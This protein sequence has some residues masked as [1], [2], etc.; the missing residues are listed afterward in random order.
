[1]EQ[2][3]VEN[4][5]TR[6]IENII[7]IN[8]YTS[9]TA[10]IPSDL[11]LM[12]TKLYNSLN[13]RTNKTQYVSFT[14]TTRLQYLNQEILPDYFQKNKDA[15]W[16]LF[17]IQYLNNLPVIGSNTTVETF[18]KMSTLL[19]EIKFE[20]HHLEIVESKSIKITLSFPDKKILMVS[21]FLNNDEAGLDNDEIV[22]SFFINRKLIASDVSKLPSFVKNFKEYL[23]L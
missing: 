6:Q 20:G 13:L 23:S 17:G 15:L 1:M 8:D 18:S 21:M 5:P 16:N 14:Q 7:P 3:I 9:H 4:I 12:H 10:S 19:S 22:F 2:L 11:I